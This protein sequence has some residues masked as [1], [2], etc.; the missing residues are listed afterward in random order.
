M[1]FVFVLIEAFEAAVV[2]FNAQFR[3]SHA[4][5]YFADKNILTALFENEWN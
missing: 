2:S 5:E 1:F 3:K 4:N